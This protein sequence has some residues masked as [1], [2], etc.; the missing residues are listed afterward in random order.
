[1]KFRIFDFFKFNN[2]FFFSLILD[3]FFKLVAS[4]FEYFFVDLNQF[5]EAGDVLLDDP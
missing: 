5:T 3:F 1:M 4:T 2:N